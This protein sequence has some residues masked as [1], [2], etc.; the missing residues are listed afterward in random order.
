MTVS[1]LIIGDGTCALTA[2]RQLV[3]QGCNIILA[4]LEDSHGDLAQ[5]SLQLNANGNASVEWLTGVR[6]HACGGFVGQFTADFKKNGELIHRQAASIIMAENSYRRTNFE[7]YGL[8]SSTVVRSLSDFLK[9]LSNDE[10]QLAQKQIVFLH[11]L[12]RE[13]EPVIAAEILLY[14]IFVKKL[15]VLPSHGQA[16]A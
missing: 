15:P 7:D 3:S 4:T 16:K 11:G 1:T 5:Q 12:S 9:D 8:Q 13:S 10:S 14:M 6:L 2:A